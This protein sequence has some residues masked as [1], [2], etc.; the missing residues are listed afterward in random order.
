MNIQNLKEGNIYIT[1]RVLAKLRHPFIVSLKCAFQTEK[2][3]Y[4]ALEYVGGGD[5]FQHLLLTGY[6]PESRTRFYAAQLLLVLEFLYKQ[7]IIHRDLKPENILID[8]EGNI[9]ITDFGLAKELSINNTNDKGCTK[10]FCGTNEYMAPE[11]ILGQAYGKSVDWWGLGIL[12]FE[13][14]TGWPPWS[15]D[16]RDVLF[17]KILFEPLCTDDEKFSSEAKDLLQKMLKKKPE[18]RIGPQEIKKHPFFA[19]IDFEKLLKKK[20]ESPY[21][22]DLV[23]LLSNE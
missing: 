9:K 4:I 18:E 20:V 19:A 10:T 21:K 3:L 13:M 14:L 11:L 5:L 23:L 22:P 2:K 6:F 1:L 7:N 16:N 12:I 17:K 8:K 15:D